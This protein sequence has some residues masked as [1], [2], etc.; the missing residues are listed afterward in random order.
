M[1]YN[2]GTKEKEVFGVCKQIKTSG[3]NMLDECQSI[4][5][6]ETDA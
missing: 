6:V 5:S 2:E 1:F 3:T 4:T